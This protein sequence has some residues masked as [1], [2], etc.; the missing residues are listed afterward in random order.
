M[1]ISQTSENLAA[2]TSEAGKAVQQKLVHFTNSYELVR[3]LMNVTIQQ[4]ELS[5]D[6]M[7]GNVEDFNL[8]AQARSPEAFVQAELEVIRRCSDR[9]LGA[10]QKI[11]DELH[12]T[13]REMSE[14]ATSFAGVAA[15]V[16]PASSQSTRPAS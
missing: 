6:W 3:S 16:R 10:A 5:R 9:A 13:W 7:D 8:L 11:G 12:Q 2:G 14:L 1:S 4:I 15:P